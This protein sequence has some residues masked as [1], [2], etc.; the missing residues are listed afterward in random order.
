MEHVFLQICS[1]LKGTT[2]QWIDDQKVPYA[3]KNSEW[4]GFDN[5]ESYEVKVGDQFTHRRFLL[6]PA[7]DSTP[8]LLFHLKVQYMKNMKFGGAFVWALDLDDFKGEFCGEGAHPLLS[9]LRKL[10]D[11]GEF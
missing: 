3:S 7:G 11:A 6:Q 10:I 8:D 9:H 1:F 5:R 2:V 4:V